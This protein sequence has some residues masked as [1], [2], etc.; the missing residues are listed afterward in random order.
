LKAVESGDRQEADKALFELEFIGDRLNERNQDTSITDLA[1]YLRN[2]PKEERQNEIRLLKEFLQAEELLKKRMASEAQPL[3]ARLGK[4]FAERGNHLFH[5]SALYRDANCD[6]QFGHFA[7]SLRKTKQTLA[8]TEGHTWGYRKALVC[9]QLGTLY[10]RMGQDSLALKE[11][12][13]A[14]KTIRGMPLPDATNLR[15]MANVY[16]NLGDLNNGIA[17][18]RESSRLFLANAPT[19][20]D[21]ASIYN[22]TAEIYA[23]LGNHWLALLYAKQ[24]FVFSVNKN[25]TKDMAQAA[26]FI[27]LEHAQLGQFNEAEEA[28]TQAF[29]YL[30][31]T[32]PDQQ[33]YTKAL[34][35]TGVGNLR[36]KQGE[37]EQALDYYSRAKTIIDKSQEKFI[38]MMNVLRAR[39]EAYIQAKEFA[40]AHQDLKLA[41]KL[42]EDYRKNIEERKSKSDFLDATQGVYDEIEVLNI[43]AFK[44][45]I[46]AFNASE[47]SRARALLD[48]LDPA[49]GLDRHGDKEGYT[50]NPPGS[51]VKKH[52]VSPL[53]LGQVQKALP[54][55]LKLVTYSVT[56]QRTFIF[57]VTRN[58]FDVAESEATT[59]MLDQLVQAY[60]SDLK[61]MAP[62]EE[63]SKKSALLY[64]YLIQPVEEKIR[65]GKRLCIVP[66]K[67]LHYLPFAP[68]VDSSGKY[69]IESYCLTYAP[70]ASVLVKCLEEGRRKG[71][72]GAEKMLAVGDPLFNV[73]AF[74]QLKKLPDAEREVKESVAFYNPSSIVL[75]GAD[76]TSENVRT[77]LN[78]CDVAHFSLH[79][80]VEE[81]TPW[82]A[83]LVLAKPGQEAA[84][85]SV[86]NDGLLRLNEVYGM[87][88]PRTKLVVL[89]ACQSGLGQYYR[90]EGIVSLVRPFLTLKVP[91]VV[92]SLWSVESHATSALMIDFHRQ[93]KSNGW[94]AGQA[95]RAAQVKMA[96]SISN[97]HP[98]YWAPFIAVGGG[99]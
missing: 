97:R 49:E 57:V 76:A 81:K 51:P 96:R 68:L 20:S 26:L 69:L 77:A 43:R 55:D 58:S 18:L 11:C 84:A 93:R 24:A 5:F 73:D 41:I 9:L 46:A 61:S 66:D 98:Y 17:C 62:D 25:L 33:G 44:N 16:S 34:I 87:N 70:S 86:D 13:L 71:A 19:Y 85:Q 14:R 3:L 79:C 32:E 89:S 56:K 7:S 23:R 72:N 27:S 67:S 50:R 47:Q 54:T 39:A 10:S 12:E 82:L 36:S 38:P 31:R 21:L 99:N 95:L 2:L 45:L 92:A 59:E 80:L 1:S 75:I 74:P 94:E 6:Y 48:D 37:I 4:K 91:T 40:K 29:D 8:I 22:S 52:E 42:I 35:F 90:G 28:L 15:V 88:L 83:A 65:D 30:E 53:T 78:D 64:R 63:M 60:L